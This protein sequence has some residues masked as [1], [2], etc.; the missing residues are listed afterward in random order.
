ML[1]NEKKDALDVIAHA[2]SPSTN[3]GDLRRAFRLVQDLFSSSPNDNEHPRDQAHGLAGFQ[4]EDVDSDESG[5]GSS[6]GSSTRR[7]LFQDRI[8]DNQ[9]GNR[10]DVS[11]RNEKKTDSVLDQPI[12]MRPRPLMQPPRMI[13]NLW[14]WSMQ[15]RDAPLIG[16]DP[17]RDAAHGR[18][19]PYR[20]RVEQAT[21][22]HPKSVASTSNSIG[23]T[24]TLNPQPRQSGPTE[25]SYL[26]P[27]N[28]QGPRSVHGQSSET[29]D[30]GTH[31]PLDNAALA[32]TAL[33]LA[34]GFEFQRQVQ[35][36]QQGGALPYQEPQTHS[37]YGGIANPAPSLRHDLQGSSGGQRRTN[38]RSQD[39]RKRSAR[40]LNDGSSSPLVPHRR[41]CKTIR[42]QSSLDQSEDMQFEWDTDSARQPQQTASTMQPVQMAPTAIP[43]T[44]S[45][46][47]G[48][49]I[50]SMD[51]RSRHI[52]ES[53]QYA[54]MASANTQQQLPGYPYI[55]YMQPHLGYFPTVSPD[56]RAT[57]FSHLPVLRPAPYTSQ[58]QGQPWYLA[59]QPPT[60]GLNGFQA[61]SPGSQ[62]MGEITHGFGQMRLESTSLQHN[63]ENI[64]PRP[65]PTV[66]GLDVGEA[67]DGVG[68]RDMV[69][70]VVVDEVVD[71]AVGTVQHLKVTIR[72]TKNWDKVMKRDFEG[73]SRRLDT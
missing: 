37:V 35:A 9:A 58:P 21:R 70:D 67:R 33:R 63:Q 5:S 27:L 24:N 66:V 48:A 59:H 71:G 15:S 54:L 60:Q 18:P 32:G 25:P 49:E 1:T 36:Q 65:Q 29:N 19:V 7:L 57:S 72:G 28:S 73:A 43:G 14:P 16:A 4:E 55:N 8:R 44:H 39:S 23:T 31:G 53:R 11:P 56:Q 2:N 41:P 22:G 34:E 62:V 26:N 42:S 61:P 51:W 46:V 69:K 30:A 47:L 3:H 68:V 45:G 50:H 12:V 52:L 13:Q 17:S 38:Q 10:A 6:T 64:P 40:E 20:P